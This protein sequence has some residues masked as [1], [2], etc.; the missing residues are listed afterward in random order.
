MTKNTKTRKWDNIIKIIE[1]LLWKPDLR[2][3][4]CARIKH[5][6]KMSQTADFQD[7]DDQENRG[8]LVMVFRIEENVR[9]S[10]EQ[11]VVRCGISWDEV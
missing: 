3:Q 10:G 7:G 9:R 4:H 8:M 1:L 2:I 11:K 6:V 5:I